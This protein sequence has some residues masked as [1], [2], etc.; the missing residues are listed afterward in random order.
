M[1]GKQCTKMRRRIEA[2]I[3]KDMPWEAYK[4]EE[5]HKTFMYPPGTHVPVTER[6]H[7]TFT[8]NDSAH[9][10]MVRVDMYTRR[11][12]ACGKRQYRQMK[13]DILFY[14]RNGYYRERA[15]NV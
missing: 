11:L 9:P 1:N 8:G 15:V 2:T 7:P 5:F 12:H 4:D 10:V 6:I 13:Q 14:V 3:P